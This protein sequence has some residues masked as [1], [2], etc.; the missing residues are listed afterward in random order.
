MTRSQRYCSDELAH[1]VGRSLRDPE[2]RYSLLLKILRE[3][4]LCHP[5]KTDIVL[6][7]GPDGKQGWHVTQYV[8]HHLDKKLSSNEKYLP[9]VICFAD[10]PVDELSLHVTKYSPFGLS[11]KRRFLLSKGANPVF[12]LARSAM[13][14]VPKTA[15]EEQTYRVAELFDLAEEWLSRPLNREISSQG[16]PASTSVDSQ[17]RVVR[18]YLQLSLFPYMKFFDPLLT[19]EHKDNYYLEREWRAIAP[20]KFDLSD[21][22]RVLLPRAFAKRF[23]ADLGDFFGQVTFI[24]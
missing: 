2:E 21:V 13:T 8:E 10:I 15:S 14:G 18:D 20:I 9:A 7:T 1:F 11:F 16:E 23:R 24:G 4:K 6:K 12:Y 5:D 19:D 3:G 17:E 22:E